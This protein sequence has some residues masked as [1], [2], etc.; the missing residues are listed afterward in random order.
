MDEGYIKLF[1]SMTSWEWYQDSNTKVVFLHLLLNANWDDSRFRGYDIPKG[2][3]VTGYNALSKQLGISK[4]SVRTAIKHLKS[5][6]EITI[7]STNKFSI[8]SIANWEKFQ[9]LEK[10]ANTQ[11]NTQAGT[12]L[13]L[14]QH[15]TNTIKEYKENKN[16]RREE[17]GESSINPED[18]QNLFNKVCIFFKPC[19]TIGKASLPKIRKLGQQYS[20]EEIREVFEKANKS[21]FLQG[22]NDRGW[23]ATFDWII[24][25]DNFEKI[26][27]GNYDNPKSETK[28][29]RQFYDFEEIERY[30]KDR[31][32]RGLPG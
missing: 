7:K 11:N 14:N 13:T 12:Q 24:T 17:E 29:K 23:S 20:L 5:T 30:T 26:R 31:N 8:I 18:V 32:L 28:P 19:M 22:S 27:D 1:R 3:L 15:S 9:V 4:Q 2:S 25:P 21:K 6:G 10:S 16:I